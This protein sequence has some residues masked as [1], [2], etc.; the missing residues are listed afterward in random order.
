[1]AFWIEKRVEFGDTDMAGIV[2]FANYF[3]YMEMI[4]TDFLI[5]LGISVSWA[6]GETRL[7]FPRVS[8]TCNYRKP[9]TFGD[10]LRIRLTVENIGT[11]SITYRHDF[12]RGDELIATGKVSSVYCRCTVD[13]QIQSLPI[14]DELRTKML[15][16]GAEEVN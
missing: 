11:K 5:S 10:T 2:Y 8:A 7:G 14:P 1:M 9:A 12:Y 4:E 16:V 15:E 6:D 3:R 13:H